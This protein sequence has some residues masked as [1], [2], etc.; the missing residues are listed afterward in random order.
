MGDRCS[1]RIWDELDEEGITVPVIL[2]QSCVTTSHVSAGQ[3]KR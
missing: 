1:G 2:R 3:L